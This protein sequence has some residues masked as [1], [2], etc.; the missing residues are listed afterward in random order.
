MYYKQGQE[1]QCGRG[2]TLYKVK[3]YQKLENSSRATRTQN[4]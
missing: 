1:K 3:E 4:K 2:G